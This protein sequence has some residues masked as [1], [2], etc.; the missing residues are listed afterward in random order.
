MSASYTTIPEGALATPALFNSRFEALNA[1]NVYNVRWYGAAGDGVT[2]DTSAITQAVA[3]AAATKGIVYFPPG[4][5]K[6]STFTISNDRV[7][8]EGAG[9]NVSRLLFNPS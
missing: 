8:L 2:D 9:K 4:D 6:H 5:Y 3:A 7:V 1:G